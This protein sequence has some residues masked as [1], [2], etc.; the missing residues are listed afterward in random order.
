MYS[1]M[2]TNNLSLSHICLFLCGLWN[3]V[4]LFVIDLELIFRAIHRVD[5]ILMLRY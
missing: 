1:E 2:F 4:D 3:S 5:Y